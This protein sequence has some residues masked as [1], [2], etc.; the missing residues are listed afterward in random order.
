MKYTRRKFRV[1]A[2]VAT[3]CLVLV[4]ALVGCSVGR[5]S[6]PAETADIHAVPTN[7]KSV[8]FQAIRL[9][10]AAQGPHVDD[11]T[12][13]T[14]FNRSPVGAGLAAIQATVRV[15][16]ATDRQYA[17]IGQRM[18]APGPGR[19]AWAV[20][21]AQISISAAAT[22]PPKIL[23]YRITG[24]TRDRAETEIFALQ[25]DS[26]MTRHTAMVVWLDEDWKLSMPDGPHSPLVSAVTALPAD[27]ITLVMR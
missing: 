26:S 9:P 27:A 22:A 3:G 21:R 4:T 11:G 10:V 8:V 13:A 18:V 6:V 23:G 24:Y 15:S 20:A 12:V 16:V 1:D 7:L 5:P 14:G 17:L 19:D 2:S 25:P